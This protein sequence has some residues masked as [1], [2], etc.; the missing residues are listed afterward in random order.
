MRRRSGR[1]LLAAGAAVSALAWAAGAAAQ[2]DPGLLR[3][4]QAARMEADSLRQD[5][6]AAA[7]R[8]QAARDHADAAATLRATQPPA[9]PGSFRPAP[10]QVLPERG[11][12]AAALS[13]R[14]DELDRLTD[15]RLAR[16]NAA[17]RAVKP[18]SER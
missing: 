9:A 17:I 18:A 7:R 2:V 3:E 4:R 1:I 8:T 15:A 14:L 5:Q 16:S 11:D 6:L 10:P 12:P 13:L